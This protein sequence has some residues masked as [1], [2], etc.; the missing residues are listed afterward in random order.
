MPPINSRADVKL[1]KKAA[2][3]AGEVCQQVLTLAQ[4]GVSTM[5][6]EDQAN[7]LLTQHR[8][9]APFKQFENSDDSEFGFA[10]CASINNQVVN[11]P[12]SPTAVLKDGDLF[13]IALG[14]Q[15]RGFCGK[16]ARTKI[17]GDTAQAPDGAIKLIEATQRFFTDTAHRP[18]QPTC[19]FDL[20]KWLNQCATEAQCVV[21]KDS[22]GYGIGTQLHQDILIPNSYTDTG[23]ESL[24]RMALKPNQGLVP[25]PL[26]ALN[27]TGTETGE[28]DVADDG[29]TQVLRSGGL[30]A[31]W[32]ETC[33]I[34]E[35]GD[36][37]VL[38]L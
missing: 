14:S 28:W 35:D 6:L 22:A 7:Q 29:W 12:P 20:S 13:S 11:A 8:A 19:V 27:T 34:N 5:A 30:C 36:F 25:M 10:L 17:V 2:I 37:E 16:V 38:S 21:V 9:S 23:A 18:S 24:K 3:I 4:P 33:W 15:Y 26:F 1:F 31:H 32:A